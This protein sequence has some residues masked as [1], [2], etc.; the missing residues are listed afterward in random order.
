MPIKTISDI[1]VLV[2]KSKGQP[3]EVANKAFDQLEKITGL[4]GRKMY[5]VYFSDKNEYW[6]CAAVRDGDENIK[7]LLNQEIIQGGQYAYEVLKGDHE[8]IADQIVGTIDKLYKDNKDI[9]D[10]LRLPIEF[11]E[12][13]NKIILMV[14]I[15]KI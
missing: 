1:K 9:V 10:N 8:I 5:G 7:H 4:K 13:H 6:A 14:P 2:I 12:R 3:R 15:S 11:Y